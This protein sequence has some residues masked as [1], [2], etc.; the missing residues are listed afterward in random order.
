MRVVHFVTGGFSGATQVAT[1]LVRAA[2]GASSPMQAVLVLRRKRSTQA[3]RVQALRDEGLQVELVPGW[4]NGLTVLALVRVLRRLRP[5]VLLAHGFPEH[6]LGRWAGLA[7]GVPHLVHVEHNAHERYTPWRRAQALWLAARTDRFVG[8]SED[9]RLL[10]IGMGSPEE[11]TVAIPNG[12]R[13]E[14][15]AAADGT[16]LAQREAGIVMAARFARQKDHA[17]LLRALHLLK[18]RGLAPPLLLAGTGDNR[19]EREVRALCTQLGLDAQVR[20]L[21]H[22]SDLPALLMRHRIVVLSS[23][24]EGFG[25]SL[26]EGMAAGCAAVGSDVP[27]IRTLIRSGRTGLLVPH[28]DAA[29]LADALERLLTD[30]ALACSLG[31]AGRAHALGE[32]GRDRMMARY[33]TLLQSVTASGCG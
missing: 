11:R 28:Q 14:R 19:H 18:A 8:V 5:D 32:F 9:V 6:L 33:E 12:I 29:A 4:P 15:F 7:A 22:V 10:L 2:R 20:F 3:A 26:A 25:L 24:Y 30:A 23:H 17:T 16:P 13:L 31:Q 21:G 1:D 27:G